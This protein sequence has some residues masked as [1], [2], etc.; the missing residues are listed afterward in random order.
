MLENGSVHKVL[1]HAKQ[2][3][4]FQT[5]TVLDA[6]NQEFLEDIDLIG[7][8]DFVIECAN[9]PPEDTGL[10]LAAFEYQ[11]HPHQWDAVQI[12]EWERL[13]PAQAAAVAEGKPLIEVVV[14]SDERH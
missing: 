1:V 3:G 10:W 9:D 6:T 8:H 4:T 14:I 12:T 7:L 13:T 11:V 5:T 2:R